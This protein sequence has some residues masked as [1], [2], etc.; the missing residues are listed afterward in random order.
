M[1]RTGRPG[2]AGH[3]A[4]TRTRR[5][6]V[7]AWDHRA[8][9]A[10]INQRD[11]IVRL[12]LL[13]LALL[14][15]GLTACQ[16]TPERPR[17][18]GGHTVSLLD[19]KL[20]KIIEAEQRL[21]AM[22]AEEDPDPREI[23]R[24]FHSV[25]RRYAEIIARNPRH[26][27]SRLLYGKLLANFGDREGARDQFLLAA[28][29]DPNVAVIHQQLGTYYAEEGDHT[30]ALAYALNA[31]RIEPETAA[32]HFGLG[33]LLVAFREDFLKDEV[34][35]TEQIDTDLLN[36]FRTA[37]ELEPKTLPLQ[38]RYGEAFYDI[39]DPDWQTALAHWETL[40][41]RDD[42]TPLQADAI[43]LHRARCLTALDRPEEARSLL[44][45]VQSPEL[46][47]SIEGI[48]PSM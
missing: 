37:A 17:G 43:R 30:R 36:A 33:Q 11:L 23:E 21:D 31:I 41:T 24:T 26:L 13:L 1:P 14:A 25:A 8:P 3:R 40:A 38:F 42:L 27:E 18:D 48:V 7:A 10:S 47:G 35:T 6:A 34:F 28:Q 46:K 29:I 22:A 15:V 39:T 32:Y 20:L 4:V 16:T 2:R 19:E 45:A 9:A 5:D 12:R 44:E